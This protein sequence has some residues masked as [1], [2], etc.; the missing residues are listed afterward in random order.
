MANLSSQKTVGKKRAQPA[1]PQQKGHSPRR[2]ATRSRN[3]TLLIGLFCLVVIGG[4]ALIY[5]LVNNH[6]AADNAA[7]AKAAAQ[8][9]ATGTEGGIMSGFNAQHTSFNPY[10]RV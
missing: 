6:I 10:E 8:A 4:A 2:T 7:A 1:R 5:T 9:Y 3:K